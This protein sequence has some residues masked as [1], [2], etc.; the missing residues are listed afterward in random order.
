MP[1]SRASP[2][3]V[4]QLKQATM[5]DTSPP[6]VGEAARA[7]IERALRWRAVACSNGPR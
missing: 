6:S 7:I 2:R 5:A 3:L 4:M 1:A